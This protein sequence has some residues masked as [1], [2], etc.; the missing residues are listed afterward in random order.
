MVNTLHRD[1]GIGDSVALEVAHKAL[2]T[3]VNLYTI[4]TLTH[5]QTHTH[6]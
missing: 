4:H 1:G 3:T 6:T 5:T 2:D